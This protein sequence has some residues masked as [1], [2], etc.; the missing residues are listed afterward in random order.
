MQRN[1][2]IFTVTDVLAEIFNLISKLIRKSTFNSCREVQ[3]Y[4][5]VSRTAPFLFYCFTNFKSVV[6][7]CSW[8]AFRWIFQLNFC[9]FTHRKA[10]F[11]TAD[12]VNC[13]LLDFFLWFIEGILSLSRA[14]W[15]VKVENCLF[16]A[17]K[18]F[19]STLNKFFPGLT[20]NLESY[21]FRHVIFFDKATHKIKFSIAGTWEA[22]FN[23]LKT[24]FYKKV[25][26]FKFLFN[27]HRINKG[28]ISVAKINRT[29]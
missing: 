26:K 12:T 9:S 24:N 14:C 27:A 7:F 19:K 29:P 28:L 11:N 21:I 23:L 6:N 22:Y 25:K 18:A 13:N 8:K 17:L 3:N 5:V 15:V 10:V 4:L 16:A 2:Y 1:N 20:Q